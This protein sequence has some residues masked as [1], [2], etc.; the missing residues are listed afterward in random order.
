MEFN[1]SSSIET[2]KSTVTIKKMVHDITTTKTERPEL[3]RNECVR[4]KKN[5]K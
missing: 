2:K 5:L 4:R 3:Y 1:I